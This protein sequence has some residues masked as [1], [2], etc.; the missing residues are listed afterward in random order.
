MPVFINTTNK[1]LQ[2]EIKGKLKKVSPNNVIA[3]PVR[4]GRIEG[5]ER[6]TKEHKL[7][8][9]KEKE[10]KKRKKIP[11]SLTREQKREELIRKRRSAAL[12]RGKLRTWRKRTSKREDYSCI[13]PVLTAYKKSL[14]K[15]FEKKDKK[16]IICQMSK[17]PNPFF[18]IVVCMNNLKRLKNLFS[19]MFNTNQDEYTETII[20]DNRSNIYTAP[21]ALNKGWEMARGEWVIFAHQDILVCDEYLEKIAKIL[22]TTPKNIGIIGNSGIT[23]RFTCSINNRF[24][25]YKVN[26]NSLGTKAHTLDELILLVHR[27]LIEKIKFD[28][29]INGFHFYGPDLCLQAEQI[30]YQNYINSLPIRH[31]SDTV[32][33]FTP[34]Q[35]NNYVSCAK[36]FWKKWKDKYKRIHTTTAVFSKD[37]CRSWVGNIGSLDFK[38]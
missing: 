9:K 30:G 1:T 5:L 37:K 24:I 27:D 11:Q 28:E 8:R 14:M 35:K 36:L 25:T 17:R 4:I 34:E 20:V 16:N 13:E 31:L 7:F 18:S 2:I 23:T 6:Y 38:E 33:R 26:S 15:E 19:Y 29:S 32:K 22:K 10:K 21:E 3:G 12:E